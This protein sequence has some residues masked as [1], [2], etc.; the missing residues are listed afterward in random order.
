[1]TAEAAAIAALQQLQRMQ[2]SVSAPDP[3]ALSCGNGLR[4]GDKEGTCALSNVVSRSLPSEGM[5]FEEAFDRKDAATDEDQARPRTGS[6]DAAVC[7]RRLQ[8][9]AIARS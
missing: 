5:Q 7:F 8:N 3:L 1:M 4:N 2:G 9:A 6:I